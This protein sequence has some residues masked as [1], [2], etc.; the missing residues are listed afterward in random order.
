M[1]KLT[2]LLPLLGVSA[3]AS[4]G[5]P[6]GFSDIQNWTGTGASSAAMVLDWVDGAAVHSYAWGYHF[7]GTPTAEQMLRDID[8]ADPHLTF[9]FTF[10]S[11]FGYA[12]DSAGY[13]ANLDG[14]LEL[15]HGGFNPGDSGFWALYNGGPSTTL[16]SWS[17]SNFGISGI[18]LTDGAWE[19]LSW[20]PGF[21]GN[22]P[23]TPVAAPVPEPATLLALSG[24]LLLRRKRA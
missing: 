23:A 21:V 13:D 9:A 14:T 1:N 18:N 16:P 24:L 6:F 7:N 3:L 20:A 12:L 10:F 2:F 22:P 19:G 8:A 11:G 15:S 17:E 5:A 4:A